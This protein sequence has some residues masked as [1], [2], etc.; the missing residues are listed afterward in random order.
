MGTHSAAP[1]ARTLEW[2]KY[3]QGVISKPFDPTTLD[4]ETQ[5]HLQAA[6]RT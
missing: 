2:A 4:P 3:A 5:G 1:V 6:K